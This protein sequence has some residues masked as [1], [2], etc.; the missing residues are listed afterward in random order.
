MAAT[1]TNNQELNN[2]AAKFI[3]EKQYLEAIRL[4]ENN[5]GATATNSI[6]LYNLALAY[7]GIGEYEQAKDVLKRAIDCEKDAKRKAELLCELAYCHFKEEDYKEAEVLCDS[8]LQLEPEY[9]RGW[10]LKGVICFLRE[11]Y[12][13]AYDCFEK[14]VEIDNTN[15]D[16]WFNLADTCEVLGKADREK[17][18]RENYKRLV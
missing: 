5:I 17:Q 7:E 3:E 8:V 4:L 10:N 1:I 9:A 13:K 15:A 6:M 18:A 11:E 14:A 12:K 16:A 2:Q